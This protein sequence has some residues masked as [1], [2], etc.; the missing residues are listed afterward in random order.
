VCCL[1]ECGREHAYETLTLARFDLGW[2]A[3]SPGAVGRVQSR[4]GLAEP[5]R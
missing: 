3:D 4:E 5:E 2:L 1:Y